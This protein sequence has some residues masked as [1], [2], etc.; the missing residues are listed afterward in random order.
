[1]TFNGATRHSVLALSDLPHAE[2]FSYAGQIESL[3]FDGLW[4]A[5]E[6]FYHEPYVGLTVI[7]AATSRIFLGPGVTDPRSRH[8][9]LTAAAINSINEVSGGRAV[10]GLG[11]GKSG[12]SNLGISRQKSAVALEEAALVIRSLLAGE[13]A[14][15]D[16]KV[17]SINDAQMKVPAEPVPVCIAANGPLTLE[18]AGAVADMVMIPHCR[19]LDLLS[20]KLMSV[21]KGAERAGRASV[22]EVILRLDTAIAEEGD[23]ARMTAKSRLGRTLWAAYPNIAFLDVLGLALPEEL[24][25]RLEEAGPFQYTFDLSVFERFADAIPDE[26]LDATCL[27]GTP[28]QVASQVAEIASAG[29]AEVNVLPV[30]HGGQSAAAVVDLY[31]SEVIK[32]RNG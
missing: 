9:A 1:M 13:T 6:R 28:T 30:P 5:D 25:R 11:A 21:S 24:D 10:L 16:G 29:V 18:A 15:L 4:Y 26:I 12:F 2:L 14:S 23:L 31:A 8:P 17:V 19:S 3:G 20:H 22:P 27:A 7:A 32:A